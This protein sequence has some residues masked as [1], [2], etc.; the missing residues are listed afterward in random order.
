MNKLE[1]LG[2]RYALHDLNVLFVQHLDEDNVEALTELFTPEG[3][4]AHGA[5]N[6]EGRE[7]IR[8]WMG[9]SGPARTA[10]DSACYIES[11]RRAARDPTSAR[12]KSLH[13]VFRQRF[14]AHTVEFPP[15]DRRFH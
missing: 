5:R 1:R 12:T 15:S 8:E 4:Y 11:D 9:G 13:I 2:A 10:H 14:G 3:I 6:T 7:A